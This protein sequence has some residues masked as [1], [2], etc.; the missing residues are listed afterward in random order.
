MSE[1]L[2]NSDEA[3]KQMTECD[4]LEGEV[5]SF[6]DEEE[7]SP[8][9]VLEADRRAIRTRSADPEIESLHGKHKRGKLL[10]QPEFQRH[11]VWDKKKASRLIESALLQVPIPIIYLAEEDGGRESVIDGQQRL[12]SFFSY[13]DNAW[14]LGGAFKLVGMQVFP[15]LNGKTFKELDDQLQDRIR[16]YQV[17][18]ITICQDSDSDLKFEIF[19]RLNTGSVPL[20]DMELRNCVYRGPYMELLK[21]LSEDADFRFVLGLKRADPRMRDVELVLRF[22]AFFSATYLKY[23]EP[24]RRFLNREMEIRRNI[25]SHS[26]DELRKAFKNGVAIAK[27]LFGANAFRRFIGGNQRDH[28]GDWKSGSS[29]AAIYDIVMGTFCERDKARVHASLD[30]CRE[31]LLD[32]MVSDEGFVDA[33]VAGT[34]DA[35]RVRRRFDL[36]R[37]RMDQVLEST[38]RQARCFSRKLKEELYESDATCAICGQRISHIDDAAVDH[39]EQYWLGGQTIPEN[40]RL[41]HRF[42]NNTRARGAAPVG[43]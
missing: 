11:F 14:P 20:N 17:R 24:M 26:A 22:A 1:R 28:N 33:V 6:E 2:Q 4:D 35:Q 31:A 12:T 21:E 30:A 25:T 13:V 41:A 18:A 23:Q 32:L 27:S 15:E 37:L 9:L 19:Y 3:S 5:I 40:A 7:A 16:Y 8:S 36:A 34:G 42:C 43:Q 39:I 10:L 38:G 29:N